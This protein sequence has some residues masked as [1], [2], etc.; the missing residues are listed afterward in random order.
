MN[1]EQIRSAITNHHLYA[2]S[3]S[4]E[5][6]E[7]KYV[8]YKAKS[9]IARHHVCNNLTNMQKPILERWRG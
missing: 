9:D 2:F 7:T 3:I 6:V 5:I 8:L 1:Y 4:I